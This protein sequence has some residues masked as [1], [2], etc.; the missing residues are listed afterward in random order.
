MAS[1]MVSAASRQSLIPTVM[2]MREH[3]M[4]YFKGTCGQSVVCNSNIKR[5]SIE[6]SYQ[7]MFRYERTHHER[8]KATLLFIGDT[9]FAILGLDPKTMTILTVAANRSPQLRYIKRQLK[10]FAEEFLPGIEVKESTKGV[11]NAS[12]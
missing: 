7:G 8:N 10:R 12:K 1:T 5:R 6:I 9:P 11:Q 2:A 4:E 3:I